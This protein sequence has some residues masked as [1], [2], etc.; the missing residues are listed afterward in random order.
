MPSTNSDMDDLKCSSDQTLQ[1]TKMLSDST[2]M[3]WGFSG[4][5]ATRENVINCVPEG[6]HNIV[7]TLIDELFALGWDGQVFQAK[8]KFG[9]LRF[10]VG[11]ASE[12]MYSRIREAEKDSANTCEVCGKPGEERSPFGWVKTLCEEHAKL[13]STRR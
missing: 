7:N 8:E 11:A 6:W 2:S 13:Y 12:D 5:P 3:T 10:Y 1:D 4:K 9:A